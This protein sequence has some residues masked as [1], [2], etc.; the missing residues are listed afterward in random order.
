MKP[1]VP[2]LSI[3][4]SDSLTNVGI[5]ADV[6]TISDLGGTALT[7]ITAITVQDHHSIN[8]VRHLDTD[9]ITNQVRMVLST[10][11]PNAIKVGL[12]GS[13]DTIIALRQEIVGCSKIVLDPGITTTSGQS[14]MDDATLEAFKLHLIPI[15]KLLMLKC[16]DAE[17]LLSMKITSDDDM[18]SA[19]KKLCK[20]G[21]EWVLLRGGSHIAGQVTALLYSKDFSHFFSSYNIEGW[22][23][24]GV[25][26]A[27]SSAIA[28][29][30]AL[31]DDVAKAISQAHIY[32]HNQ[33]VYSVNP[34]N[35]QVRPADIYN[36]LLS[37]I[38]NNYVHEHDV[39]FYANRLCITTRYLNQVTVKMIGYSPKQVISNYL[40][41][42]AK[43]LLETSTL[44]IQEISEK[45][46][47]SSQITFCRFFKK[48]EGIAPTEYR[49]I[50]KN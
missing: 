18:M 40:M 38:A 47:F 20:M 4:G 37:L 35:S 22:R 33:V 32:I 19:A 45:L 41:H 10:M 15:A 3:S 5:Q 12:V 48:Q 13:P 44:S 39:S 25:G 50:S 28:T 36:R 26:G 24:H 2:V 16:H 11:H 8:E 6:K 7:A 43:I 23:R 46:G 34:L 9:L 17:H 27:L 29:R 30:L 42:E 31:G 21:A 14:I 49:I 1:F